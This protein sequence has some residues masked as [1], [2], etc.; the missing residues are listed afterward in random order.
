MRKPRRVGIKCGIGCGFISGAL[1]AQRLRKSRLGRCDRNAAGMSGHRRCGRIITDQCQLCR[2]LGAWPAR[3]PPFV[4]DHGGNQ[5]LITGRFIPP[6]NFKQRGVH[7]PLHSVPERVRRQRQPLFRTNRAI[8]THYRDYRQR[9]GNIASHDADSID[10]LQSFLDA[11]RIRRTEFLSKSM[12]G[13][14]CAPRVCC[15]DAPSQSK[16][17]L[18]VPPTMRPE[19][20]RH[21]S[22]PTHK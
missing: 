12:E 22:K 6:S 3:N 2:F 4:R 5:M 1:L 18:D 15:D 11:W 7:I 19:C 9:I 16:W 20:A 10:V 13:S 14:V 8:D 17:S 21:E